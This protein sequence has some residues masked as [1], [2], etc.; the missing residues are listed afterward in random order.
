MSYRI[1]YDVPKCGHCGFHPQTEHSCDLSPTGNVAGIFF[2]SLGAAGLSLERDGETHVGLYALHDMK[3]ETAKPYLVAA[4]A[5]IKDPENGEAL[6]E[7]QPDNGWGST[8]TVTRT[9]TVLLRCIN[10]APH[11]IIS[12]Y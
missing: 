10:E 9:Y 6:T 5:W 7:M 11:G 4:L 8:D 12:V 2:A 1:G 3:G